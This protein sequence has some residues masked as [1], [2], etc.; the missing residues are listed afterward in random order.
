MYSLEIEL[1]LD[2][3]LDV[4]TDIGYFKVW[5]LTTRMFGVCGLTW[6]KLGAE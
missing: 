4:F 6:A 3:D 2:S 5:T 1:A